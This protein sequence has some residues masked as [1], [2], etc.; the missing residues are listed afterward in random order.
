VHFSP[1]EL[2]EIRYA[3]LLHDFGKVGVRENVLVKAKKLYPWH[4]ERI[5]GR[6]ETIQRALEVRLWKK[7]YELL[8]DNGRDA[9]E[10]SMR[11]LDKEDA[12]LRQQLQ[13]DL[14]LIWE[15]NEPRVLEGGNYT[16]LME[17]AARTWLEGEENIKL[18]LPEETAILSIPRGSLTDEERLE[19][20][21][22]V[23]HSWLFLRNIPWTRDLK[24]IPSIAY[25]HHER[26]DAKGYPRGLADPAIPIQS[27]M[28]GITDVFDALTASDRPYKKALSYERALD[29]LGMEAKDKKLDAALY[30]IFRD[31]KAYL[32]VEGYRK[33]T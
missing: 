33:A 23:T 25:A 27:K 28:M 20:E 5:A 8:R 14:K 22:H 30:E 32:A 10:E 31:S 6:G 12:R 13:D 3:S 4:A 1:E 24:Q 26:L 21:S 11:T 19:I 17:I 9:L 18:L 29:I 15:T 7:R 16:R 2:Q